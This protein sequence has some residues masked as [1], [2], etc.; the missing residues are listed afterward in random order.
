MGVA[1]RM[2]PQRLS[3]AGGDQ[4][5]A[6]TF[7]AGFNFFA[8]LSTVS[9]S[10]DVRLSGPKFLKP[11]SQLRGQQRQLAGSS[12]VPQRTAFHSEFF[13]GSEQA[14]GHSGLALPTVSVGS[15]AFSTGW[16]RGSLELPFY[17]SALPTS[18]QVHQ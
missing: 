10:T 2:S 11:M 7:S 8:S 12:D 9:C 6:I 15:V 17:V 18:S 1:P 4:G 5:D 13:H 16:H 3:H 14:I